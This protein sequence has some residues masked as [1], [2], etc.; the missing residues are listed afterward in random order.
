MLAWLAPILVLGLVIFVHE[1][2]HFLAAKALG[3]Y[4]PRFSLGWGRALLRWRPKGSE[5]EYVISALPIG[6]Y[7]RMASREDESAQILEGGGEEVK[8]G[9]EKDPRWDPDAMVPH[10]PHPVPA[11]RW[12]ESKPTWA[13]V[14]ILLAGVTMNVLLTLSVATGI[15]A[16]KGRSYYQPVIDSLMTGMPA[17][18]AG[19]KSGD[20]VV[21]VNGAPVKMWNDVVEKISTSAGQQMQVDVMRAGSRVSLTV[22]PE[23]D[24]V[25]DT[26]AGAVPKTGQT[27]QT[28]KIGAWV[29]T[30]NPGHDPVSL[31]AAGVAGWN[32]TWAQAG[33]VLGVLKG[34]FG[35]S[36]SV[37][38][39]G[40]PIAIATA[41]VAAARDGAESLFALIAFLSINLAVLNLLPVPI[42]DGGQIILTVAEGIRGKPVS[43]RVRESLMKVGLVLIGLLFVTVMF[44]DIKGLVMRLFS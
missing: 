36:V 7:V 25:V 17:E 40:G 21:A 18:Q 9:A 33:A 22:V 43:M 37:K 6:G 41:S 14:V 44:N 34:L 4:A 31:G 32:Y 27:G 3:V 26:T 24:K 5:T 28:G 35:G 10:G 15:F 19:F 11:N 20:S 39:L 13:R 8:E 30:S 16:V 1:L 38:Q 42:L 23:A 29:R 12:F 2:G